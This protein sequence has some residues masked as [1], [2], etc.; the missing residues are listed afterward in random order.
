MKL[1]SVRESNGATLS[2]TF[3]RKR[4]SRK[5]TAIGLA[6]A[7]GASLLAGCGDDGEMQVPGPVGWAIGSDTN[8]SAVILHTANGGST[9]DAQGNKSLWTGHEGTDISAVDSRTAWAT[10][11]ATNGEG[12]LILHTTDGGRTWDIQSLPE[13][14]PDGMKGIKGISREEAWAVG[15]KGPVLHTL[16]GGQ[17][18]RG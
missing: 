15:L 6:A 4:W 9:W 10:L 17:L 7:L 14:I 2:V 12:G 8:R 11:S 18:P 5:I 3:L 16:D 13:P 1:Q